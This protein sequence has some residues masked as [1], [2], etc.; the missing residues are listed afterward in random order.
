MT[1]R[2][3]HKTKLRPVNGRWPKVGDV[4]AIHDEGPQALWKLGRVVT[5][6]TGPDG[7]IRVAKVKTKAGLIT[8]PTVK[9]YPLEVDLDDIQPQDA[10]L[11]Q[12]KTDDSP[13]TSGA[14]ERP[15]RRA[16][17]LST[18]GWQNMLASGQL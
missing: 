10:V 5:L 3:A 16:A 17:Q 8:R 1:L 9:L 2:E 14:G 12:N 7:E 13:S 18:Q 6:L 15:Q 11:T 4:V